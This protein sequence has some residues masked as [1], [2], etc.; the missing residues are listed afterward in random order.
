ML[1]SPLGHCPV[2]GT[3]DPV[4]DPL[5]ALPEAN[6]LAPGRAAVLPTHP[7]HQMPGALLLRLLKMR[8]EDN[9]TLHTQL[10]E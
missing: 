6:V 4:R 9:A 5:Q 1:W 10:K 3:G 2:A 8:C 7:T